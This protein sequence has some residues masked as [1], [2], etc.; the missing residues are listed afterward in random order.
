MLR[1]PAEERV[2]TEFD[3]AYRSDDSGGSRE[4]EKLLWRYSNSPEIQK[5]VDQAFIT[6]CGYSLKTLAGTKKDP[7]A[8]WD[9]FTNALQQ[10]SK[11]L[12]LSCA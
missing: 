8:A 11:G 5:G 12:L 2:F 6:V 1:E 3:N 4:L 10:E 9:K 7:D